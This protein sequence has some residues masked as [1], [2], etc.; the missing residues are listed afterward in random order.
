MRKIDLSMSRRRQSLNIPIPPPSPQV[1]SNWLNKI[2]KLAAYIIPA[3]IILVIIWINIFPLGINKAVTLKVGQSGD[4]DNKKVLYVKKMGE[5]QTIDGKK[6]RGVQDIGYIGFKPAIELAP[7]TKVTL[8]LKGNGVFWQYLDDINGND[9]LQ[10]QTRQ[11]KAEAP[12]TLYNQIQGQEASTTE[13]LKTFALIFQK[14]FKTGD[15]L[16]SGDIS[17]RVT[18]ASLILSTSR[19]RNITPL[20]ADFLG[21]DKEVI[22]VY[23]GQYHI[24]IDQ[25]KKSTFQG[26]KPNKIIS[27]HTKIITGFAPLQE[28]IAIQDNCVELDGQSQ[29]IL[30]NSDNEFETSAFTVAL[31]YTP[32]KNQSEKQEQIIG[33]YNWEILQGQNAISFRVGRNNPDNGFYIITYPVGEE[34]FGKQH[35]IVAVY[36]PANETDTAGYIQLYLDNL[37]VGKKSL[38]G[39]TMRTDYS[40]NLTIGRGYHGEESTTFFEGKVCNPRIYDTAIQAQNTEEITLSAGQL[41]NDI[42]VSGEGYVSEV[43]AIIKQ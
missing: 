12:N 15:V 11:W 22:L 42:L 26:P 14:T 10:W 39:A 43:K 5:P 21:T 25:I 19:G 4:T 38:E 20:P 29:L 9:I 40:R 36:Q 6:V 41:Q 32:I 13:G 35:S 34:F 16:I 17:L 37:P 3:I 7:E 28:T 27:G 23:D 31:D 24:F 1:K 2:N 18:A 33:H 8:Q 30:P